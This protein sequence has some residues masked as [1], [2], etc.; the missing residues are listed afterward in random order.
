MSIKSMLVDM[1]SKRRY[2]YVPPC[3]RCGS[4]ITGYKLDNLG[5]LNTESEV[6]KIRRLLNGELVELHDFVTDESTLF[7]GECG[8]EWTGRPE[9]KYL[10][11][12]EIEKQ[13]KLR[14]IDD[15]YIYQRNNTAKG[16]ALMRSYI[17]EKIRQKKKK[18]KEAKKEAKRNG[19]TKNKN[20]QSQPIKVKTKKEDNKNV[21]VKVKK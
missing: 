15:E 21:K 8:I 19:I 17:K 10:T 9:I 12:E 2:Y 7:C 18:D 4:V 13:K 6:E 16:Q 20:N 1:L 14:G 5:T 11:T 3:P